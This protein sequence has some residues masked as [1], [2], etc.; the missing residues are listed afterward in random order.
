MVAVTA[1][2]VRKGEGLSSDQRD[3]GPEPGR[4]ERRD[5]AR[6]SGRRSR[7]SWATLTGLAGF[8]ASVAT[9]LAVAGPLLHHVVMWLRHLL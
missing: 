7:L 1:G 4:H 9:V 5:P 3:R 8:A 2:V 6:R